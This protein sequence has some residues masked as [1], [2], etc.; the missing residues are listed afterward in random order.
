MSTQ[1]AQTK[2]TTQ[3]SQ[4]HSNTPSSQKWEPTQTMNTSNTNKDNCSSSSSSSSSYKQCHLRY[5]L[6]FWLSLFPIYKYNLFLSWFW[7]PYLWTTNNMYPTLEGYI[8][9]SPIPSMKLRY[10]AFS[11]SVFLETANHQRLQWR[12]HW[13]WHIPCQCFIGNFLKSQIIAMAKIYP[14]IGCVYYCDDWSF[15]TTPTRHH[16]R[17]WKMKAALQHSL[18]RYDNA[19]SRS[20]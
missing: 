2:Q 16:H 8:W 7:S 1:T 15:P 11:V 17:R 13:R 20:I 14:R 5:A 3:T 4:T 9:L 10:L 12:R 19:L 18:S 6:F